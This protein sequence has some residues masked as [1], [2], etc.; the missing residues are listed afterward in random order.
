MMK[1][2]SSAAD[3]RAASAALARQPLGDTTV[4]RILLI[5]DTDEDATQI[6][7]VITER[8]LPVHD[9]FQEVQS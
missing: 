8:T 6:L 2:S 4:D 9:T 7:T 5:D 3:T 1:R